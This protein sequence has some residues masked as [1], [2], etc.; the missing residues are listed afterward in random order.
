[1][2]RS[3]EVVLRN[4][5]EQ[6]LREALYEIERNRARIRNYFAERVAADHGVAD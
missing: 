3:I 1:M 2:Q 6:L 4:R 5:K